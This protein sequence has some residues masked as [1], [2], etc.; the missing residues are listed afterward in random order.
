ML[1][2]KLH[3]M[4]E[5]SLFAVIST[6]NPNNSVLFYHYYPQ[7]KQELCHKLGM[8]LAQYYADFHLQDVAEFK[9]VGVPEDK[10]KPMYERMSFAFLTSKTSGGSENSIPI[11]YKTEWEKSARFNRWWYRIQKE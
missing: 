3:F 10:L 7:E 4:V 11:S 2:K 9:M 8:K 6:Y 1:E 5:G